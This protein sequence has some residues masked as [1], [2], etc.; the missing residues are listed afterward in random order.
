MAGLGNQAWTSKKFL[1]SRNFPSVLIHMNEMGRVRNMIFSLASH[2]HPPHSYKVI[3]TLAQSTE[4]Q[5]M[6]VIVD[7]EDLQTLPSA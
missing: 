7:R 6:V 5:N 2:L 4:A 3:Y 1:I